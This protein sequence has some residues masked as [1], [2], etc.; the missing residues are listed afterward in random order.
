MCDSASYLL[1]NSVEPI[2]NLKKILYLITPKTDILGISI[3]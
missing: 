2:F 3:L 1:I